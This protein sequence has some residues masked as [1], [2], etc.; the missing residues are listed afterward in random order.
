MKP[1]ALGLANLL[2]GYPGE[3]YCA[4]VAT[5][6]ARELRRLCQ[7]ET[8]FNTWLEKTDWIQKTGKPHELGLH[9]ADILKQRIEYLEAEVT[10]EEQRFSEL[11]TQ[12]AELDKVSQ[13][14]TE[15]LE[16]AIKQVPELASVPGIK[17]ALAKAQRKH[18]V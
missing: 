5:K 14:L 13:D 4:I 16:Y 10:C 9:R 12:F 6:A 18:N 17:A 1:Q 11:W 3:D 15:A 8:E 7:Y 2:D